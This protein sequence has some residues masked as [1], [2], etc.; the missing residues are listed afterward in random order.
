MQR[1]NCIIGKILYSFPSA[2][3]LQGRSRRRKE[4]RVGL[5]RTGALTKCRAP[6][7]HAPSGSAVYFD[8][9]R[10]FPGNLVIPAVLL[11]TTTAIPVVWLL[12]VL[13]G[14]SSK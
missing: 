2:G 10:G 14:S 9:F 7:K 11:A 5:L 4:A 3:L 1:S 13:V 12:V 8:I 6:A